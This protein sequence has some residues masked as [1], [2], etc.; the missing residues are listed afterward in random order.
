MIVLPA[1]RLGFTVQTVYQIS[2]FPMI[3]VRL[4]NRIKPMI[5]FRKSSLGYFLI[6][7]IGLLAFSVWFEWY[8]A[9]YLVL[10]S[11]IGCL[12]LRTQEAAQSE[13]KTLSNLDF[14]LR[15]LQTLLILALAGLAIRSRDIL[16]QVSCLIVFFLY[17]LVYKKVVPKNIRSEPFGRK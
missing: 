2:F 6:F 5:S 15:T 14:L 3:R 4:L 1:S 13:M 10:T 8:W 12:F 7:S 16:N 9:I 17:L 11:L